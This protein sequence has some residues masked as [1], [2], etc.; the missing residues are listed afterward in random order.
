MTPPSSR[1]RRSGWKKVFLRTHCAKETVQFGEQ[2]GKLLRS[3]D[4][5]ALEGEL[6]SGKTHLIKGLAAGIG[7][8]RSG[9]IPS[10][11]FT[12]IHEYRGRVPFYHIDLYRLATG[13]EAEE[14]GIE[15]YLGREGVT[16]IEWAD[17]IAALLPEELLW[18][19]LRYV[20][21][22]TRSIQLV[23]KGIRYAELV[24]K[25]SRGGGPVVDD[26]RRSKTHAPKSRAGG[27]SGSRRK[28]KNGAHCSEI[29]WNL[30]RRY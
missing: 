14:L 16:A 15:E 9:H 30:G 1:E 2:L 18:M 4:V 5:V 7:V 24:E 25:L 27:S 12:L 10:P 20:D 26:G 23:G 3:G 6:G 17:K 13:E 29:R 8:Q 21:L 22:R 28:S 11:S 19:T